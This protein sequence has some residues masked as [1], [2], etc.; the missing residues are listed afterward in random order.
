[1][2]TAR[3]AAAERHERDLALDQ[4]VDALVVALGGGDEQAVDGAARHDAAQI[5]VRIIIE[6]AKQHDEIEMVRLKTDCTP[7]KTL[8]KNVSP[9]RLV[10]LFVSIMKPMALVVPWRRL[11]PDWLGT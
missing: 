3:Q 2:R 7:A 9:C 6:R 8:M 4:I 5:F 11:R 10:S 1:M